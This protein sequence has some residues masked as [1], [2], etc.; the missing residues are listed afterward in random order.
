MTRRGASSRWRQRRRKEK[1]SEKEE[2][3]RKTKK[4]EKG[5]HQHVVT[6]TKETL[7]HPVIKR[8]KT[9][10]MMLQ[11]TVEEFTA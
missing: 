9:A 7:Q 11:M 5:G 8:Q 6:L 3:A 4:E 10:E 2:E 1:R